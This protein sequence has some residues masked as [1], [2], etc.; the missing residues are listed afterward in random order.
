[1]TISLGMTATV[2]RDGTMAMTVMGDGGGDG[3]GGRLVH[4]ENDETYRRLSSM[5]WAREQG[6]GHCK[7]DLGGLRV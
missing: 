7:E 1:V 3:G 4:E 2:S 5:W 6:G